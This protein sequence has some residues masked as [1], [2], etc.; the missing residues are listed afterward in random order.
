MIYRSFTKD[1]YEHWCSDDSICT[2]KYLKHAESINN[3]IEHAMEWISN[4]EEARV[5]V[6][7]TM[8]NQVD[9]EEV[10]GEMD[11]EKEL[12]I[13]NCL[14]EGDKEDPVYEHLNPDGIADP[15]CI[16]TLGNKFC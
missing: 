13:L 10:G 15:P 3:V 7:E 12:H 5:F 1:T 9:T 11:A 6:E 8:A 14:E 16:D 2:S 4:V